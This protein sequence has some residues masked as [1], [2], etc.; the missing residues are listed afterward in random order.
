M[1]R[2]ARLLLLSALALAS[3]CSQ[4]HRTDNAPRSSADVITAQ[5]IR[6]TSFT[7]VYDLVAALRFRWLQARGTDTVNLQPGNVMVRLDDNELG[8]VQA[9]RSLSPVGISSIHFVDPV[10][11][12][13]RWGLGYAHGAIVISTRVER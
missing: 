10:S 5:D 13:G 3:S 8:T 9:L 11:A 1:R 7:N 4:P 2:T 6:A 12:G